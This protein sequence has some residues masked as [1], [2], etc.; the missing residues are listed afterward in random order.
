MLSKV[1]M[2]IMSTPLRN[3]APCRRLGNTLTH[4]QSDG[5]SNGGPQRVAATYPLGEKERT[6]KEGK[7]TPPPP[8]CHTCPPESHSSM[9]TV[10]WA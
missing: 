6:L 4:M 7:H 9:G 5:K 2:A 10:C 8:S 1:F 3:T